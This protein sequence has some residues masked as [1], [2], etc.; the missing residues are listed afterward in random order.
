[1][2]S[3]V[4]VRRL[5]VVV[6]DG[7]PLSILSF[8]FGV[9]DMAVQHGELP[10]LQVRVVAGEPDA[11]ITGG[12]LSCPVPYDLSTIMDADLVIV[13]NWGSVGEDP[14]QCST[15]TTAMCSPRAAGRR[16]WTSVCT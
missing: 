11:A 10:G 5:A 6:F 9:F 14:R 8:A 3:V 16:A 13:P 1:M 15:W 12:G 4:P 2:N 7:V